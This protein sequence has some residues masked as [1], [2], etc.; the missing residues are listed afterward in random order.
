MNQKRE[1]KKKEKG[2][3]K[4]LELGPWGGK[5]GGGSEKPYQTLVP[6]KKE[7]RTFSQFWFFLETI[8]CEGG[9]RWKT[10]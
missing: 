3:A 4:S 1:K 8:G 10:H 2:G 5:K 6:H 9:K 7:K